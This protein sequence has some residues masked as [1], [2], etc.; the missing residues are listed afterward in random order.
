MYMPLCRECY[1][2]KNKQQKVANIILHS[3]SQST[4]FN[5]DNN[6]AENND[7]LLDMENLRYI[8]S[9]DYKINNLTPNMQNSLEHANNSNDF[10]QKK[11]VEKKKTGSDM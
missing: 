11:R 10:I 4:T 8:N 5:D 6:S 7:K 2:E 1:N 3:E 9:S